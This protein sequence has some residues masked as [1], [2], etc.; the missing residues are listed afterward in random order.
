MKPLLLGLSTSVIYF[1]LEESGQK[2]TDNC[3]YLAP[4]QTDMLAGLA[5]LLL[6]YKS[7]KYNDNLIG[8]IGGNILGIHIQQYLH[9]K[10]T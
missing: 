8:F 9:Y 1:R 10:K 2:K 5:G 3:S 4:V 6:A 7:I